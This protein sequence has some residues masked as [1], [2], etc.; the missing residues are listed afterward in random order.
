MSN[1]SIDDTSASDRRAPTRELLPLH[2][3]DISA[4]AR[5]LRAQ[6]ADH[7]GAPGHVEMLNMLARATGFRN[8]Q[9]LRAQQAAWAQLRAP[10]V[11]APPPAV[12]LVKIARLVRYFD[13][14][15][16]LIRWPGKFSHQEPCFW[17]L[18]SRIP[19]RRTFTEPEINAAIAEQHLFGDHVL[20]R[21]EMVNYRM[22]GRTIDCRTYWR[23]ERE[24]PAEALA[25][26]RTVTQRGRQPS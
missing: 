17:V 3:P 8:F 24:P 14:Q 16:R 9:H 2:A 18:W 19:A 10:V 26:I 7:D 13:A 15:G 4:V 23:V 21:R 5:S 20:L 6:L 12:D 1:P 22:I 25:L 11:E